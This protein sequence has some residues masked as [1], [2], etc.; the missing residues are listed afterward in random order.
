MQNRMFMTCG[1][2]V[3]VCGFWSAPLGA[4]PL[5]DCQ[6]SQQLRYAL[7]FGP[8]ELAAL[9]VDG[10]TQTAIAVAAQL[11][12]Q[13]NRPTLEPLILAII[14]ARQNAFRLYELNEEV[15]AADQ[16]LI[17]A[18]DSL[19]ESCSTLVAALRNL[20][21]PDQRTKHTR[22]DS[23]RLLEPALALLDLTSQQRTELQTAQRTRDLVF[24][25]HKDRKNPVKMSDARQAFE[26]AVEAALSPEQESERTLLQNTLNEH[27]TARGAF[28]ETVCGS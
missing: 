13:Q 18:I 4:E 20:M 16:S 26:A 5:T 14:T 1:L 9:N 6:L 28:E 7:G 10:A 11:H 24:R 17:T 23:N 15:M 22:I 8:K 19:A 25:H 3:L 2:A 21:T 12:V 27:A